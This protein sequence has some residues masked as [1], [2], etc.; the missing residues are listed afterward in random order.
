MVMSSEEEERERWIGFVVMFSSLS[1]L[2]TV[3][4]ETTVPKSKKFMEEGVWIR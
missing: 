1:V 2:K 4:L 3:E